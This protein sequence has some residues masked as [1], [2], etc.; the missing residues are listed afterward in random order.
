[1]HLVELLLLVSAEVALLLLGVVVELERLGV[2]VRF[3]LS[4]APEIVTPHG[5]ASLRALMWELGPR[6]RETQHLQAASPR[7]GGHL[8]VG[9]HHPRAL[10]TLGALVLAGDRLAALLARR[11]LGVLLRLGLARF[12]FD[13]RRPVLKLRNRARE[14]LL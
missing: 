2:E 14:D 7:C 13:D 6:K 1:H 9:G 12:G 4:K 10:L 3:L 11:V 5:V 8:V